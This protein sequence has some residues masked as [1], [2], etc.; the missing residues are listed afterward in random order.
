MIRNILILILNVGLI[1]STYSMS[2]AR[3]SKTMI[4]SDSAVA[5]N[6][7][8]GLS[9]GLDNDNDSMTDEADE[10]IYYTLQAK[11]V[12]ALG[13]SIIAINEDGS[14][15]S[16]SNI[17][18]YPNPQFDNLRS[19]YCVEGD[20]VVLQGSA[21]LGDGSGAATG[22]AETFTIFDID[23][24]VVMGPAAE[25]L[26]V[27]N[28]GTLGEGTFTVQFEFNATDDDPDFQHPGCTQ[29]IREIIIILEVDCGDF[30]WDGN[31]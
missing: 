25:G 19:V 6:F 26:A 14:Q 31:E 3:E 18:Y 27:L 24:N 13:F 8:N 30:P 11:H 10:D 1:V 12:D 29:P 2:F 21:Q 5:T 15:L 4:N 7:V 17:C 9:D 22:E 16:T 23:G 20:S 28:P